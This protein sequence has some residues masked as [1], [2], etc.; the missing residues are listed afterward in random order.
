MTAGIF[1]VFDSKAE[2]FLQPYFSPTEGTAIRA[3][4]SAANDKDH[5]FSRYAADYT[6]FQIG[7]WDDLDGT[8]TMYPAKLP[9]GTALEHIEREA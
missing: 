7:S 2:A 5:Q 8:I 6:L 9:L 1:T 4:A 3:F